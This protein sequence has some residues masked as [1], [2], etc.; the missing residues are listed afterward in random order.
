[1]R[2]NFQKQMTIGTCIVWDEIICGRT[3]YS[4]HDI[5][6]HWFVYQVHT[7]DEFYNDD[8][9]TDFHEAIR[10]ELSTTEAWY[11]NAIQNYEEIISSPHYPKLEIIQSFYLPG[12]EEVAC[13]KT[14]W[15]KIFQ[16]KWKRI[17]K[18]NNSRKHPMIIRYRAIHGRWP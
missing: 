5:D 15:L 10:A 14:F 16:R 12:L 8:E 3:E 17:Y 9:I 18:Q 1:M 11:N 13:I 7:L 6:L 2:L 4:S